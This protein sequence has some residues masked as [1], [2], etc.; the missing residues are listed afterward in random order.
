MY[1]STQFQVHT[2]ADSSFRSPSLKALLIISSSRA[3]DSRWLLYQLPSMSTSKY[4]SSKK[5]T[6]INEW[7]PV[8]NIFNNI[9]MYFLCIYSPFI[10]VTSTYSYNF[11]I[12]S[13]LTKSTIDNIHPTESPWVLYH[14]H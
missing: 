2:F 1:N 14:P 10:L 9:C 6:N 13:S 12:Q 7:K 3:Q 4:H 11:Y 5:H 8:F